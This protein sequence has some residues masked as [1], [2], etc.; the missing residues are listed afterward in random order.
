MDRIITTEW[1]Q[2]M[3]DDIRSIIIECDFSARWVKITKYHEMG[4]RILDEADK[5][6]LRP[7]LQHV[8]NS[9]DL[10]ER[11]LYYATEFVKRYPDLNKLPNGKNVSWHTITQK[12]LPTK[13][14]DTI[15]KKPSPLPFYKN[16]EEFIKNHDC[17][18]CHKKPVTYAH[19][20]RTRVKGNFGLPLCTE[21]HR[22][23][24]DHIVDGKITG[25][26]LRMYCEPIERYLWEI[27]GMAFNGKK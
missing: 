10:S 8:A 6:P 25:D 16:Y 11:T 22:E 20:P 23:Q 26:W 4:Q 13:K 24:E 9:L 12:L 21:C 2:R 3:L 19:W 14:R 27:V 7:L 18:L 5:M 17:I 15:T 1:Y